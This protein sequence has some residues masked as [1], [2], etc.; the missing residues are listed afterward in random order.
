VSDFAGSISAVPPGSGDP[1]ELYLKRVLIKLRDER[2]SRGLTL[3]DLEKVMGVSN[4]HLSRAER[5]LCEPGVVV[6]RR[7]C[8]ALGL[9]FESVCRDSE[10][11]EKPAFDPRT[12]ATRIAKIVKP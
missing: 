11:T 9:E 1:D 10:V 2:V 12:L 4:A 7:W 8:R 5:G 3:R 6:L